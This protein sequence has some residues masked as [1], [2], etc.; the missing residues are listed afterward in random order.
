M[1]SQHGCPGT[2]NYLTDA[3]GPHPVICGYLLATP[4]NASS[5]RPQ[6]GHAAR[7]GLHQRVCHTAGE[8]KK[9]QGFF[10]LFVVCLKQIYL[11]IELKK[12]NQAKQTCGSPHTNTQCTTQNDINHVHV[13]IRSRHV[14][15]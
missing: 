15:S 11:G 5:H 4:P 9:V 10:G 7:R 12:M 6:H 1:P 2:V 13:V 3:A 8:D 14:D